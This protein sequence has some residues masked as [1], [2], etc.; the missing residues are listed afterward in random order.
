MDFLLNAFEVF[1][2]K[3]CA[4]KRVFLS[5]N[6]QSEVPFVILSLV[7]EIL[8]VEI[9]ARGGLQVVFHN[10][11]IGA[12]FVRKHSLCWNVRCL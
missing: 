5:Q 12:M 8:A 9:L 1:V 2:K 10:P 11:G 7:E 6:Q 4:L 3:M